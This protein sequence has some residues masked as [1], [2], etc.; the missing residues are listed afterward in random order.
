MQWKFTQISFLILIHLGILPFF[1][2]YALTCTKY[3]CFSISLA[4]RNNLQAVQFFHHFGFVQLTFWDG[5]VPCSG[6]SQSAVPETSCYS[7][8]PQDEFLLSTKTKLSEW[9]QKVQFQFTHMAKPA[10]AELH[11]ATPYKPPFF[12]IGK[13][14][15]LEW[16]GF[17]TFFIPS[18]L[19]HAQSMP[20]SYP[21]LS[22]LI[23]LLCGSG[24]IY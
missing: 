5:P 22:V 6:S 23:M 16:G 3:N 4:K 24:R 21:L 1:Q 2:A 9:F 17:H 7:R 15:K 12:Q 20:T 10:V 13:R 18:L 8:G 14:P 19:P 11:R